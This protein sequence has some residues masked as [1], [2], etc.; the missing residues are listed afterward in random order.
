VGY[1]DSLILRGAEWKFLVTMDPTTGGLG[2]VQKA[3]PFR[4]A[5]T[6]PSFSSPSANPPANGFAPHPWSVAALIAVRL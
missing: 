2:T 1:I 5:A 4:K 6:F 3:L